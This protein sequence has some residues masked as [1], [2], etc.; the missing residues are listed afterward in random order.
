MSAAVLRT[1]KSG[2]ER[3]L[4]KV[5]LKTLKNRSSYRFRMWVLSPWPS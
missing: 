3:T 2:K 1:R 4:H 5:S